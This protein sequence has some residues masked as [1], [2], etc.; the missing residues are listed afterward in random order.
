[1]A[2]AVGA[3]AGGLNAFFDGGTGRLL[4]LTVLISGVGWLIWSTN[5]KARTAMMQAPVRSGVTQITLSPKGC[6][7]EHPGVKAL[8][9]WSHILDVVVTEQGL[10]LLHSDYEYYPI[11]AAAFENP[12]EME[13]VAAQIKDWIAQTKSVSKQT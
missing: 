3:L 6:A 11:E 8:Y 1:M 2:L 12:S 13:T 9:L 7:V 10:L 4:A 5:Q